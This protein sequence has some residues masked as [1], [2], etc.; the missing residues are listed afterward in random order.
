MTEYSLIVSPAG[1]Q[2]TFLNKNVLNVF[3]FKK[4]TC[5]KYKNVFFQKQTYATKIIFSKIFA[6]NVSFFTVSIP[7]VIVDP[8]HG[9]ENSF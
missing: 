7:Q 9:T 4:L 6:Q 5:F 2:K 8:P 1:L 3:H